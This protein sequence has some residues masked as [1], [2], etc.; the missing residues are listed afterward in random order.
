MGTFFCQIHKIY[1]LW[2]NVLR[3]SVKIVQ[4]FVHK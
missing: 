2:Q 3:Y 1:I 4:S